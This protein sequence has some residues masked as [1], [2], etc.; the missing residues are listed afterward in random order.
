MYSCVLF[1]QASPYGDIYRLEDYGV[2]GCS[3]VEETRNASIVGVIMG[4]ALTS[5][6]LDYFNKTTCRSCRSA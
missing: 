3:D 1:T 6:T 4:V 5:E 2:M